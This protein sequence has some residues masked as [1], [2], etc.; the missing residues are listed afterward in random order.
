MINSTNIGGIFV[1]F[2]KFLDALSCWVHESNQKIG[3]DHHQDQ[4][5]DSPH[6]L[7]KHRQRNQYIGQ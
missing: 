1:E 4:L 6:K 7:Q 5:V 3:E 2:D